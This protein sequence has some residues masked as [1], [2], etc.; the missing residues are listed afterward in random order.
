MEYRLPH[1]MWSLVFVVFGVLSASGAVLYVDLNSPN[2]TPPYADWSTAA[3]NIQDAIDAANPGDT[4]LVTNGVYNSGVQIRNGIYNGLGGPYTVTLTNRI[5]V[6]NAITVQSVNGAGATV[7]DGAGLVRCAYLTGGAA[8]TGF[9]LTNGFGPSGPDFRLG[10]G[11]ASESTNDATVSNCVII[12]NQNVG[13]FGPTLNNCIVCF[14]IEGARQCNLNHCAV[15]T[16]GPMYGGAGAYMCILNNC[17]V[18]G[19]SATFGGAGGALSCTLSNCVV[20]YNHSY[21]FGGGVYGSTLYN[22]T[23]VSNINDSADGGGACLSQLTNCIVYDNTLPNHNACTLAYCCTIPLSGTGSFTNAPL[24]V[25][26]SGGNFHL[27]SNSPCIN[28]G[29]DAYVFPTTDLDGKPRISGGTVDIG[30]Y[31]YQ[32]PVVRYVDLNSGSPTP[33]YTNWATA[34]TNIQDAVDA[35]SPGD[36]VLVS[37]GVYAVGARFEQA[38]F[39]E[40]NY[41]R[42]AVTNPISIRSVNGPAVTTIQGD[43]TNVRC[44]YLASGASLSGFTLTNGCDQLGGGGVVGESSNNVTVSNCVLV[45]NRNWGALR[46]TLNNCIICFNA[47]GAGYCNLNYC[48]VSTNGPQGGGGGAF[49]SRLTN[50]IVYDNSFPNHNDCTLAYCCTIPLSGPGSFTNA[51]LFVDEGAGNFHLQSN[52]PCI[53]AGNNAYT[54]PTTDLDGN[55]RISGDTVDIGAYEFQN[56]ASIISY[57]WLEQYGLAT[58][59]SADFVDT[60]HDGMNNWQEWIAGTDPTS[61][62]SVLKMVIPSNNVSG[63]A[64]SWQ[65]VTNRTYFLQRSTDL[66]GHPAFSAIQSNLL[67]QAGTTTFTDTNIQGAASCFYRVGLQQ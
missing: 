25:D 13:A 14:N 18:E 12:G 37:N 3:T 61:L 44:V 38:N 50:C 48:R 43:T 66:A 64:V 39:L 23:V 65:S 29:N 55:P 31:E 45:G 59:G 32:F 33:P 7:I 27:Q 42:V 4:V 22:C 20:R 17:I 11:V 63:L 49:Y 36:T 30:A 51:P 34:A 5:S 58:N 16:N 26:E 62:A 10:G 15:S 6:T 60:D 1:R 57:A 40:I 52:S 24:F 41:S 54:F 9:T 8:L 28:A 67:G 2:P 19:N 56:P 47:G 21:R 35:T 53:N 46:A